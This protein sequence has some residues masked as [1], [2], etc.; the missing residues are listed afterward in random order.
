MTGIESPSPLIG[1]LDRQGHSFRGIASVRNLRVTSVTV[2]V[3]E[4]NL[5]SFQS[6]DRYAGHHCEAEFIGGAPFSGQ[7][8]MT[9]SLALATRTFRTNPRGVGM[10]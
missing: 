10:A 2:I 8:A 7:S 9:A 5:P 4:I 6:D 3:S 1:E